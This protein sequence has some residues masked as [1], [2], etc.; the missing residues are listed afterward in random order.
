METSKCADVDAPD[1]ISVGGSFSRYTK[2]KNGKSKIACSLEPG[3]RYMMFRTDEVPSPLRAEVPPSTDP[4]NQQVSHLLF[5]AATTDEKNLGDILC[6]ATSDLTLVIEGDDCVAQ[7]VGCVG[8]HNAVRRRQ[9]RGKGAHAILPISDL[10]FDVPDRHAHKAAGAHRDALK[11]DQAAFARFVKRGSQVQGPVIAHVEDGRF[12]KDLDKAACARKQRMAKGLEVHDPFAQEFYPP[13]KHYKPKKRGGKP[14]PKG[15]RSVGL[16]KAE[17]SLELLKG[18]LEWNPGPKDFVHHEPKFNRI[19]GYLNRVG[20][21]NAI[22]PPC[23]MYGR[24]FLNLEP[25]PKDRCNECPLCAYVCYSEGYVYIDRKRYSVNFHPVPDSYGLPE[26]RTTVTLVELNEMC[27]EF[28]KTLNKDRVP[29]VEVV[30]E[31]P[32][33]EEEAPNS[34]KEEIPYFEDLTH[35]FL[36]LSSRKI[37]LDGEVVSLP[38]LSD[39]ELDEWLLT[40][41]AEPLNP[42]PPLPDEDDKQPPSGEEDAGAWPGKYLDGTTLTHKQ[43]ICAETLR[44]T[45]AMIAKWL[46]YDQV[47]DVVDERGRRLITDR[48]V[49]EVEEPFR[50][51]RVNRRHNIITAGILLGRVALRATGIIT[52]VAFGCVAAYGVYRIATSR[53]AYTVLKVPYLAANAVTQECAYVCSLLKPVKLDFKDFLSVEFV[54]GIASRLKRRIAF[55]DLTSSTPTPASSVQCANSTTGIV[56]S[57]PIRNFL[58]LGGLTGVSG[59]TFVQAARAAFSQLPKFGLLPTIARRDFVY[60]PHKVSAIR[61]DFPL[62]GV[63]MEM[64]MQRTTQAYRRMAAFPEADYHALEYYE[65][66]TVAA[67][68]TIVE[69][70]I[71]ETLGFRESLSLLMLYARSIM[72]PGKCMRL[73]LDSARSL[74]GGSTLS[75]VGP[76]GLLS[77]SPTALGGK[78][79]LCLGV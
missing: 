10:Q 35:P 24:P 43:L 19:D 7:D 70:R 54:T 61:R 50:I 75:R 53:S 44:G 41:G 13:T 27:R 21:G 6:E 74:Y 8:N 59:V 79:D 20:K 72:F 2:E 39:D 57:W 68:A 26:V 9:Q 17:M 3:L 1:V 29:K 78:G 49:D 73:V 76:G 22:M 38:D 42:L 18:G 31:K 12:S 66:S 48:G 77:S 28:I 5:P 67:L 34:D 30:I 45:D 37:Y 14:L 69:P 16:S 4:Q 46:T 33:K 51:V 15:H 11:R 65:G 62:T 63:D 64:A 52:G 36:S 32:V 25:K 55:A 47:E 56:P 60:I 58:A 40:I 23:V 71:N